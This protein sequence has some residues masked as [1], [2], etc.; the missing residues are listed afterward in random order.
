MSVYVKKYIRT[1]SN[2]LGSLNAA[3]S[4][5][6]GGFCLVVVSLHMHTLPVIDVHFKNSTAG[7]VTRPNVSGDGGVRSIDRTRSSELG[8]RAFSRSPARARRAAVSLDRGSAVFAPLH[9]LI[10]PTSRCPLCIVHLHKGLIS[11]AHNG[12][13]ARERVKWTTLCVHNKRV[14]TISRISYNSRNYPTII[15]FKIAETSRP[16]MCLC[17]VFVCVFMHCII[18]TEWYTYI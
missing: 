11:G 7:A 5:P 14:Q 18:M 2:W 12:Q 4:A 6:A 3:S 16:C 9:K 13:G 15:H 1:Q 10:R 17:C 8:S